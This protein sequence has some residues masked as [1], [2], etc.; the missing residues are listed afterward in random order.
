MASTRSSSCASSPRKRTS[1]AKRSG[2]VDRL[3]AVLARDLS[4]EWSYLEIANAYREA[5]RDDD[6]LEWAERGAAAFPSETLWPLRQFLIEEYARRGRDADA[7]ALAWAQFAERS[8][9]DIYQE[10]QR[11]APAAERPA[12]R[13]KALVL[14]RERIADAKRERQSYSGAA[15]ADHS[16]LVDVLLWEGD[17]N[18]AL[19]EAEEGGCSGELWLA[20]AERLE[21]ER[22]DVALRL[23]QAQV[24]PAVAP[25][26][27]S[28]YER[29]AE[30]LRKVRQIMRRCGRGGEFAGYL[31]GVRKRHGRKRNFIRL[32]EGL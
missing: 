22:P 11:C 5:S 26:H 19:R 30:L 18:G 2:D 29:A 9:L 13:E 7:A 6:A 16:P 32:L 8:S 15:P 23:Y 21:A 24:D 20:L 4:R 17:V 14:L 27:R 10:L 12:W 1:I 25:A 28:G 31:E 3:A